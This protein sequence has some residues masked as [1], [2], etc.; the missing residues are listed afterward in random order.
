MKWPPLMDLFAAV[1]TLGLLVLVGIMWVSGREVADSLDRAFWVSLTWTF[2]AGMQY[3]N[4]FRH[5]N[6]SKDNG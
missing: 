2:R 5:R 4:D 1:L 6:R 3:Q